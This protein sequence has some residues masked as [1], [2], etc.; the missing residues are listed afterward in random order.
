MKRRD[1]LIVD[2]HARPDLYQ[3]GDKRP[4]QRRAF[5]LIEL[6]VVIAIMAV[7]MGLLVPAVQRTLRAADRIKCANN[8]RQLGI[9]TQCYA[10]DRE[11]IYPTVH[12]DAAKNQTKWY[13]LIAYPSNVTDPAAGFLS[14]YYESNIKVLCCPSLSVDAG[15]YA[16]NN[17]S[18]TGP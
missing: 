16:Y 10:N 15:F 11:T 13:G 14:P 3:D 12:Y 8:L 1:S 7:L 6:L 9:A 4:Q 18:G 17:A 5:T 2:A